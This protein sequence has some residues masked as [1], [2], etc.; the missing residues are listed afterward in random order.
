MAP[1]TRPADCCRTP[2]AV[3]GLPDGP[4]ERAVAVF[5]ALGDPTRIEMLRLLAAQP[6]PLC[7]CD[8][9]E[10]FPLSQPTISHHL[11]I[12]RD[13]GL[14]VAMRRGVWSYYAVDPSGLTLA[15]QML[16]D[17]MPAALATNG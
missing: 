10:R 11:K 3:D 1:R 8:V 4:R 6:A 7:V 9:V 14:V 17:L 12:L 16:G 15:R 13:A 5:R 2:V